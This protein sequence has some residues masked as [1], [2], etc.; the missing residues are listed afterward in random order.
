M[1][2]RPS[3]EN[4]E[5]V[6]DLLVRKNGDG[7][8]VDGLI[9]HLN[10]VSGFAPTNLVRQFEIDNFRVFSAHTSR[11]SLE[12]NGLLATLK[13][14]SVKKLFNNADRMILIERLMHLLAKKENTP[15][16]GAK[17]KCDPRALY[18]TSPDATYLMMVRDGRDVF[19]SRSTKG[20]FN[21]SELESAKDWAEALED[22]SAFKA[23]TGANAHFINYEKAEQTLFTNPHGHLSAL[24]LQLGLN[25]SSIGNWKSILIEDYI[26]SIEEI[27]GEKLLSFG[28]DLSGVESG[29]DSR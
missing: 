20:N 27:A 12:P 21:L 28:Y 3:S 13:E 9:E 26:A 8:I 11:S 25:N 14:L 24:Q 1:G 5:I 7:Y 2:V 19:A 6:P 4:Y 16:V 29:A 22:F 10:N 23:E 18:A 17:I 15:L